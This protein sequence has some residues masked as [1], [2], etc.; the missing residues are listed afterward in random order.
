M[1]VVKWLAEEGKAEV[2]KANVEGATPLHL[3]KQNGKGEI[4]E[5]LKGKGAKE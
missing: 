4:V 3:V 1:E 5:Y 2:D